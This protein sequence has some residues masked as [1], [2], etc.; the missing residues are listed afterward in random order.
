ML[1]KQIYIL[2]GTTGE[3]SDRTDWL[4]RAYANEADAIKD[5][6]DLSDAFSKLWKFMKD[7]DISCWV[8]TDDVSE[9]YKNEYAMLL[10]PVTELDEDFQM[11]Y[12]GTSWWVKPVFFK[13]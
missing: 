4:V 3:Y 11:Y 1:N 6:Q 10:N 2:Q 7:K 5:Q 12:T 8:H 13:E 9:E